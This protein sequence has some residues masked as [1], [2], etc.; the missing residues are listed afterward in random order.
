MYT[1]LGSTALSGSASTY[2]QGT[3]PIHL[4]G[5][6]CTG[7]EN[8]LF[9]CASNPNTQCTHSQDAAVMCEPRRKHVQNLVQGRI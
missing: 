7:D 1:I 4:A 5:L 3:G 2:G 6:E 8:S 9:T